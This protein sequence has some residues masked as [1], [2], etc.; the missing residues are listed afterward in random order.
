MLR[1]VPRPASWRL[2]VLIAAGLCLFAG[3]PARAFDLSGLFGG[4]RVTAHFA[5]PEGK[6][7]ADAEVRVFAPGQPDKPVLT[8]HTDAAGKFAFTAD[9][10][11]FWTAEAR[12]KTEVA[13]VIIRVPQ[14]ARPGR[15][16]IS[17]YLLFGGVALLL[18]L[19]GWYRARR[20]RRRRPPS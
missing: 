2:A 3:P 13:R 18:V 11:G 6:P 12:T 16:R 19:A 1:L 20:V 15:S 5:T 7:I 9:R 17:P 8:G 4:H 10:D 14:P